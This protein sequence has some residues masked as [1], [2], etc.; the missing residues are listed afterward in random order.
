MFGKACG[1]IR[2]VF[3]PVLKSLWKS[4]H[5][6]ELCS[7]LLL[8]S[9][10]Q[11]VN[12]KEKEMTSWPPPTAPAIPNSSVSTASAVPLVSALSKWQAECQGPGSLSSDLAISSP[13]WPLQFYLLPVDHTG[14]RLLLKK[15]QTLAATCPGLE[16]QLCVCWLGEFEQV[17]L[18][19][20]Y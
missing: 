13:P 6:P 8:L 14:C 18:S 15:G 5:R 4:L 12:V 19:W 16:G 9:R 7:L 11:E 10:N 1:I 3:V 17:T 20:L 2:E